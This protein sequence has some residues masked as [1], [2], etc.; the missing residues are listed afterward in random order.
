[1]PGNEVAKPGSE[2]GKVARSAVASGKDVARSAGRAVGTARQMGGAGNTG[3]VR[4]LDAH[5]ASTAGDILVVSGLL[6]TIFF[7]G[8]VD[9]ARS[10]VAI[11]LL[12]ALVPFAILAPLINPL[13]DRFRSGR[14]F[15]MF[16][17]LASRAVLAWVISFHLGGGLWL[18][19][20]AFGIIL[21]SRVHGFARGAAL[22]RLVPPSGL[23]LPQ[24]AARA[25]VFA[26][27]ASAA[28][29]ALGG[30]T[31]SIGPQWPLRLAG[32][33]YFVG[34]IV[35]LTLPPLADTE[36]PEVLPQPIGVPWRGRRRTT[37]ESMLSGQLLGV[38]LLG[39]AGL[40]LLY[41]FLLIFL[42]FAI[43]S[44]EI[45][46]G[47][48]GVVAGPFVQL[49]LVGSSFGVGTL[50]ATV[51]GTGRRVHH[52]VALQTTGIVL[53]ALAAAYATIR[54]SLFSILTLCLVT[55]I[56][57]GLA[58]VAV[59]ATIQERVPERDRPSAFART[60]TMLLLVWLAGALIGL[61][62]HVPPRLGIGAA[63][64]AA[65]IAGVAGVLTAWRLR[66]EVLRGRP[67]TDP[68][69]GV[70]GVVLRPGA[71]AKAL[72]PAP[73]ANRPVAAITAPPPIAPVSPAPAAPAPAAPTVIEAEVVETPAVDN[74][75]TPPGYHVFRPTTNS[76][77]GG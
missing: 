30:I 58:R 4:L 55:A 56:A 10:R 64:A 63:T 9:D 43:R 11:F 70:N 1:M 46:G 42:A 13:L 16:F 62:P 74:P 18:Y 29:A 76:A 19:G 48:L 51:I 5:S 39:S 61:V 60:D 12:V 7:A 21:F 50:I 66:G 69:G 52:P 32:L 35:A 23:R 34:A 27:L 73:V 49:V 14:R 75:A 15:A 28:A 37:G 47:M 6:A 54:F 17:S 38:T 77:D 26:T 68:D 71:H 67:A 45:G 59:D 22:A 44:D 25:A 8:T 41:G 40:R 31:A 24:A 57:S 2:L 33:I 20:S 36:G 3:L 72:P 65:L 53:V